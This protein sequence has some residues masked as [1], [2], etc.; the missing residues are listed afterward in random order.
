MGA[1]SLK[2][3]KWLDQMGDNSMNTAFLGAVNEGPGLARADV[4]V[5]ALPYRVAGTPG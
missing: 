5:A 1:R 3:M 2:D 4:G